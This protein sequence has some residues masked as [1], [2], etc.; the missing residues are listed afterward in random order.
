MSPP[1]IWGPAVWAL[2]H[3]LTEKVVD[4]RPPI[5]YVGLF[6]TIKMICSN[7][8]C[9]TCAEDSSRF[10]AKVPLDKV[11]TKQGIKNMIYILHNYVNNKKRKQP[12]NFK[13]LDSLYKKKELLSVINLFCKK[14]N[15]KGNM[16][17]LT[18]SFRRQIAL[19]GFIKWIK[20]HAIYFNWKP[21]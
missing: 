17:L 4:N 18:E 21:S 13:D 16:Q 20:Q 8:P 19:K 3:T 1:E 15:T 10:L 11:N 2:L 7:L 12:F 14:Y 5:L 6:N 9:P